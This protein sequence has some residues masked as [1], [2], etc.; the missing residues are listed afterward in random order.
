MSGDKQRLGGNRLKRTGAALSLLAVV[1]LGTSACKSFGC[2]VC[3][4]ETT[5]TH[6]SAP[7]TPTSSRALQYDD[8]QPR[9]AVPNLQ[10]LYNGNC[11][12]GTKTHPCIVP[13]YRAP[14]IPKGELTTSNTINVTNGV[15][16]RVWPREWQGMDGP[17][18]LVK[19]VCQVMGSKVGG[20]EIWDVVEIDR[21]H[22]NG[23]VQYDAVDPNSPLPKV[24][25]DLAPDGSV[26]KVFGFMPDAFFQPGGLG[27]MPTCTEQQNPGKY[28]TTN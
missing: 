13:I 18:D 3:Y 22:A 16:D 21:A 27:I 4:T 28:Q 24:G 1:G 17:Q 10:G 8:P 6:S 11:P 19:G 9:L 12:D 2:L 20:S 25:Y 26:S 14:K 23:A 15:S 5:P 7:P